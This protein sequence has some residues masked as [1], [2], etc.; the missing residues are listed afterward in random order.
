MAA[1]VNS[2]IE[3]SDYS[4]IKA[5]V[6]LVFGVGTGQTGYGQEVSSPTISPGSTA[7]AAQW[8][9]LRSD[10]VRSRQHQTGVSVGTTNATDGNNLLV[11]T[12]GAMITN[13]LRAQFANFANVI[14]TN[15]LAVAP[16][17][18]TS[19]ALAV[20]TRT[21]AWNNTLNHVVII[22][23][24]T[25]GNGSAN[26][27]RHFFNAGGKIQISASRA[28]GT[29][30]GKNLSW[31]TLLADM[32]TITIGFDTVTCSGLGTIVNNHGWYDLTTTDARLFEKAAGPGYY[33]QNRYYISARTDAAR[34]ALILTI[35]FADL[36]DG[37]FGRTN[38]Y[39]YD[40]DENVTG[41]LTSNIRQIRP[42]GSNVTVPAP[43]VVQ[44]GL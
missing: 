10:M 44:S 37:T 18:L 28:G 4:T 11:P 29:S 33:S 36:D 40:I 30:S 21:T 23:G 16:S 41:T 14:T 35:Q 8:L 12:S 20:G 27:M 22:T 42:T 7:T 17:Q 2:L 34:S 32:G 31:T 1:G 38:L 5:T 6:D 19:E 15:K 3:A 25:S 13:E 24:S 39:V 26:N 9:A 43:T